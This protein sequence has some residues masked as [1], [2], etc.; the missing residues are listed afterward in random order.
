MSENVEKVD[1]NQGPEKKPETVT[2]SETKV[3]E[4]YTKTEETKKPEEKK[5]EEKK[6]EEK[7]PEE[8]KD[9][10]TEN[11]T[12]D[13]K[14]KK[15]KYVSKKIKKVWIGQC[16]GTI[17]CSIIVFLT[18]FIPYS[19]GDKI[20]FS[21]EYMPIL[22][23]GEMI[24]NQL[25]VVTNFLGAIGVSAGI[26]DVFFSLNVLTFY[27]ILAINVFFSLLL[28]ITRVNAIRVI[29]KI[30]SMIFGIVMILI[31][32]SYIFIVVSIIYSLFSGHYPLFDV[33][34]SVLTSGIIYYFA[35]VFFAF[36]MISRQFSWYK[37][38]IW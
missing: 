21:Y 20:T 28:I 11:T 27:G 30:F 1:N 33:V 22:G 23:N 10:N 35:T 31:A 2:T 37:K 6:P 14:S 38:R 4:V 24:T 25:G 18:V 26:L 15:K 19:I 36:A 13:K 3:P 12:N 16:L 34:N 9:V 8:N 5:P 29:V 17:F 32:F 7:K